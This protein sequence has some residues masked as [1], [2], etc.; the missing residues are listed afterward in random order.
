MGYCW[1]PIILYHLAEGPVGGP[2]ISMQRGGG[3]KDMVKVSS[4]QVSMS[5]FQDSAVPIPQRVLIYW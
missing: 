4:L 5:Q 2:Y 1:I 3:E